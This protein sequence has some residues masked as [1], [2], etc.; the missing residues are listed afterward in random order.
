MLTWLE[1]DDPLPDTALA[2]G[3]GTD[4]PGLLAAGRDISPQRLAEAYD[5]GIFPW[6]SEGQPVLWWS[7]DPRMVLPVAE[8]RVSHSLKKTL[9]RFAAD[10]ACEL[11]IDS[12]F[13]RVIAA[14]ASTPRPGQTGT[15]IQPALR[16]AYAAWH[17]QGAVHS[18]ETW[19][20]GRLVGGLY[21]VHRG[22]M[23]YGESMFAH[24]TDASKIALAALVAFCRAEGIALIDCQ[25]RTAHLAS[26]GAREL[27]R[28]AFEQHLQH[29]VRLPPPVRWTYDETHWAQVLLDPGQPTAQD[30]RPTRPT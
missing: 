27:P 29:A 10:P 7:P 23:F 11:R 8:F 26:F 6:Y 22:R 9:R 13:A 21:G 20:G 1:A 25:Q 30:A 3:P 24:A 2:W 17:V 14:C 5:R 19:I 28:A 18:F 16:A 15:W 4:A 12:A